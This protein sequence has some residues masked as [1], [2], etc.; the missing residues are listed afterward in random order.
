MLSSGGEGADAASPD[1][2][3]SVRQ[4]GGAGGQASDGGP[5]SWESE[6]FKS[7]VRGCSVLRMWG[8]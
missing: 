4:G 6:G 3:L 5:T 8:L 2:R 7:G 1:A